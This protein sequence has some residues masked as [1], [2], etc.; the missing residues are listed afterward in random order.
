MELFGFAA[1]LIE[2]RKVEPGDDLISDLVAA[3]EAEASMEWIVGFIFTMVTGGND[4]TTGLLGGSAELLTTFRDQRE[5]LLADP[6]LVRGAI[7][8]LLRLTSPVQNLARTTTRAVEIE[9]CTIPEGMKVMLLYGSANRDE[10]EFG[11]TADQLQVTRDF[12]KMLSLGY[13]PHH[14]LGAAAAR[15]QAAIAIERLLAR[16]PDFAVDSAAGVFAPGSF[17]RR[18]ES[19]PFSATS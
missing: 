4:T 5:L 17:V 14:C 10:R 11:D 8:E 19:L 18:Y 3:G 13:G 6:T 7:D 9:G 16:F 12:D 15:L 2:R 1:E